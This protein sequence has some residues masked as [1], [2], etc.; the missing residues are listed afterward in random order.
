MPKRK[1]EGELKGDAKRVKVEEPPPPYEEP[2]KVESAPLLPPPYGS[3]DRSKTRITAPVDTI[4]YSG[5]AHIVF[6]KLDGSISAKV[7][8]MLWNVSELSVAIDLI[9]DAVA[10]Q[11]IESGG[12]AESDLKEAG[13]GR[14]M[15]S[16]QRRMA[17]ETLF[18]KLKSSRGFKAADTV[19]SYFEHRAGAKYLL[20]PR[21]L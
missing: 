19:E 18:R 20:P 11:F 9:D 13:I 7:S 4:C 10:T 12:L 21:V 14:P 17:V 6:T 2:P 16:M 3:I 5:V 15:T 8:S 1:P